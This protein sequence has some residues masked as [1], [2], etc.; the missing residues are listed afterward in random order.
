MGGTGWLPPGPCSRYCLGGIAEKFDFPS[1]SKM[2]ASIGGCHLQLKEPTGFSKWQPFAIKRTILIGWNGGQFRGVFLPPLCSVRYLR[3]T[4]WMQI[5]TKTVVESPPCWL[6]G[7][8]SQVITWYQWWPSTSAT[9]LR[10]SPGTSATA[11]R[12]TRYQ[13]YFPQDITYS[14]N[15]AYQSSNSSDCCHCHHSWPAWILILGLANSI[16]LK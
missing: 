1:Y 3:G 2:A 16:N 9:S 8:T 13:C 14:E 12:I 6:G 10:L 7:I 15:S 11:L 4:P 5:G